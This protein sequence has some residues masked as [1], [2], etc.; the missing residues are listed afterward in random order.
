ME[1]HPRDLI[2]RLAKRD[3]EALHAWVADYQDDL[4]RFLSHLTRHREAA[5][6]LTQ[7]TFVSALRGQDSFQGRC[8]MRTW[9]HRIAYH[10]YASWRRRNVLMAALS[11]SMRS[12]GREL[13]TVEAAQVL[14][15]ALHRLPPALRESFLLFEVQE[16]SLEEVA[17]VTGAPLGTVKS[18]LSNARTRLQTMLGETFS[19]VC[20]ESTR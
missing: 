12:Q 18:R 5:E 6:D 11:P 7:Q 14:L 20:Y 8:S 17:D 13:E 19:E 2:D 1:S 9:L 3:A 15:S 10:E 4:Y 16:L